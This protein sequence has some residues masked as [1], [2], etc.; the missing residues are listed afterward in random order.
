MRAV[1]RAEQGRLP[2]RAPEARA[3][4]PR[5]FDARRHGE[6][7]RAG[8]RWL[9]RLVAY[10]RV[11]VGELPLDVAHTREFPQHPNEVGLVV[12]HVIDSD[13]ECLLGA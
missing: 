11:V 2:A 12:E 10:G 7:P 5:R 9:G 13:P 6:L 3:V 4:S 8:R 1:T